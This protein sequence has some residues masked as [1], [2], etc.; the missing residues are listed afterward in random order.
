[1]ISNNRLRV[2]ARDNEVTTGLMEK[3]YV[4]SWILHGIYTSKLRD[5]LLFKGGTALSKI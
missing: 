1:M 5:K 2:L 4:N 3:D